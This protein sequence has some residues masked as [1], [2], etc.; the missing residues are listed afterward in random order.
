MATL[1]VIPE[2]KMSNQKL[3]VPSNT[4]DLLPPPPLVN[5]APKQKLIAIPRETPSESYMDSMRTLMEAKQDEQQ[6]RN[7]LSASATDKL[8]AS[9]YAFAQG[10]TTGA[11]ISKNLLLK[12]SENSKNVDQEFKKSLTTGFI[13]E[14]MSANNIPNNEKYF[15]LI[16]GASNSKHL[17][18]IKSFIDNDIYMTDTVNNSIGSFAKGASMFI[19]E[20]ATHP[21]S[22][23]AALPVVI[24]K[25]ILLAKGTYSTMATMGSSLGMSYLA[26]EMTAYGDPSMTLDQKILGLGIGAIADLTS[27]RM[28]VNKYRKADEHIAATQKAIDELIKTS[29]ANAKTKSNFTNGKYDMS[30]TYK[31]SQGK[32][33]MASAEATATLSLIHI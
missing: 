30:T 4:K 9:S 31:W 6:N 16:N 15:E 22:A 19:G 11:A 3:S 1:P 28:M 17:S 18:E 2:K 29:E 27:T 23:I 26:N 12:Q 5:V 25:S 21:L 7:I 32:E 24:P 20:L 14:Y 33:S 10:S 13:Q 8:F